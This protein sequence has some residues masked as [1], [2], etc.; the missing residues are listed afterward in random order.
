MVAKNKILVQLD[1]QGNVIK[2]FKSAKEVIEETT[3]SRDVVYKDI[4]EKKS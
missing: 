3:L 4:R 1:E 2:T